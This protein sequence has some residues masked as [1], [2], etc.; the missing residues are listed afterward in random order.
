[1][2]KKVHS[3]LP[4]QL[5]VI[6]LIFLYFS[7]AVASCFAQDY[8]VFVGT[9]ASDGSKG[10]YSYR[11]DSQSGKITPLGLAGEA[12]NPSFL[13][14]D[15]T[16]RFL[17]AV[18]EQDTLDG[19][20]NGGVSA[21][22]VNH[23]TGK[24]Q[25]LNRVSSLGTAP[26]HI[27]VDKSGRYVLVANYNSGSVAVFPIGNDGKLGPHTAFAQQ[28]G[29][30][31]N[32]QRQAGPHAHFIGTDHNNRF[33]L[34]ADLGTDQVLVYRFDV[35]SGSLTPNDPP[36]ATVTPGSGPRHV[37]FAPSANFVYLSSE[38]GGD[39]NCICLRRPIG[40]FKD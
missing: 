19:E 32:K 23:V 38:M 20:P 28:V 27:S 14:V 6:V 16:G 21:F 31:V 35:N 4:R 26:A 13:A 34:S 40:N 30:S 33:A 24:L 9:Y 36:F 39:C 11:F 15:P 7:I 1:M 10:I 12:S 2:S 22:A 17:Y 29:S 37:A 25:F 8:L 5:Q 18:N 3:K